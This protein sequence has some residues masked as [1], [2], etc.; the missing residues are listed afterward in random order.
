MITPGTAGGGG[1]FG[2]GGGWG[3]I[4]VGVI[5]ITLPGLPGGGVGPT[6]TCPFVPGT[7]ALGNWVGDVFCAPAGAA[8]AI[9]EIKSIVRMFSSPK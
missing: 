5:V 8:I 2:G 7:G 6:T 1:V 9:S 4:G 3:T